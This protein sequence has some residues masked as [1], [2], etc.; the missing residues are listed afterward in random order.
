MQ[1]RDIIETMSRI[2]MVASEAVPFAK[3]GGLADVVGALP[4]ALARQGE[5]VAVIMP[6]Y[7]SIP[8]HETESAFDNMVVYAGATPYRIDLRTKV[9][10]G[11]RFFFVEA[12]WFFDRDGLYNYHG[13]DFADNHRRFSLLALAALGAAQ[14]V[15]PCDI[16]HCHDWQAAL[17][18]VYKMDQQHSNPL[19]AGTKTLLTIHNL[20]YQGRFHRTQFPDLGLNWGWFTP[21]KLEYYG[22]VN[23]LKGGIA[24]AGWISTVSPTYARQV[25][26]PEGGFG[27]DGILRHRSGALTG[28]LNGVDYEEWNPE[29]DPF[30][31][32]H[33]SAQD[34][35]GKRVCKKALLEEFGLDSHNLDRPLIGIVSRFGA[36]WRR[37]I[38]AYAIVEIVI[39]VAGLLALARAWADRKPARTVRF[40]AFANE[41]PPFFQT[42]QMGSL[43][44]ARRCRQR[45]ENIVAMMS[46]ETIG[47][48]DAA[49]GS[50]RYPFPVG[51]FYPSRGDFIGFVS[52]TRNA[53]LVRRCVAAFRRHAQFPSE[54]G[55][56]PGGLPG[57][58]WSDHWAFWQAGYP[59]VMVT[60]TAPFRYPHYHTPQD[61]PDKLDYTSL[62]RVIAGLDKV[63]D[64]LAN[65]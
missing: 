43:V 51:L 12:P 53:P 58:G 37:L 18:P 38:L 22:D 21:D 3:S 41:E 34:L 28:I 46:L 62:A 61:T 7:R 10:R 23:F 49:K 32:A 45:R 30:L 39:G 29:T 40:V 31:P 19:L 44:Y 1:A 9:H 13:T 24:T 27:L 26:T 5:E 36:G 4:A 25:Q 59:A 64:E 56:L 50:Q 6:R 48:Y 52:N 8:W 2:L 47:C 60:D 63:L 17:V 15:F 14:T 55:A 65:Q 16:L 20:G 57:I 33:Y 11:V 54:G 42:G 35:S